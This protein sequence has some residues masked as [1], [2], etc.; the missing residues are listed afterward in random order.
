MHHVAQVTS[1]SVGRFSFFCSSRTSTRMVRLQSPFSVRDRILIAMEAITLYFTAGNRSE[2]EQIGRMLVERRLVACVN[3][4]DSAVTSI[5]RWNGVI[6]NSDEVAVLCK[7]AQS[8]FSEAAEAIRVAHSYETPC[9]VAWPIQQ[10]D[11]HYAAWL[12]SEVGHE[13]SSL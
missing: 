8:M 1:A 12:S 7:T 6:E 4:L 3:I 9:V 5:Y 13:E 10:I 11:S 2:A